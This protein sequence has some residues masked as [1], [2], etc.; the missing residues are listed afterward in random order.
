MDRLAA[1]LFHDCGDL[2]V[3]EEADGGDTGGSGCEAGMNVRWR[4]P[5]KGE[6]WNGYLASFAEKF[7]ARGA[8]VPFFEDGSEDCEG[9]G[10]GGGALNFC[11]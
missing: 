3:L 8:G 11:W 4:D 2:V 9:R 5:A 7:Q 1:Q 10:A 6:D